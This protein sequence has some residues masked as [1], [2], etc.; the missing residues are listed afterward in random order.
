MSSPVVPNDFAQV[1]TSPSNSMCDNFIGTLIKMPILLYKLVNWLLDSNG[2]LSADFIR[3]VRSPGDLIFSAAPLSESA[4]RLLCDG[5]EVQQSDYPQLFAAIGSIYGTPTSATG[6]K[7]PDYRAKFPCG[8]GAFA[9][10]ASAVLGVPSGEDLHALL[11]SEVGPHSHDL[12]N[13]GFNYEATGQS[14]NNASGHAAGNRNAAT[15]VAG[16][17]ISTKNNP[18]SGD[19]QTAT[20]H[21]NLP[22][23]LACYIYIET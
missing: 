23:F 7:L 17:V 19:N 22:P 8:V 6:F 18:G 20:P 11:A 16:L 1:I 21:N 4:S 14:V 3:G 9:G 2:N 13:A 15:A 12:D 5:R 10:G